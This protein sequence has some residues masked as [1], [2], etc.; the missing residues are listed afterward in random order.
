MYIKYRNRQNKTYKSDKRDI[1]GIFPVYSYIQAVCHLRIVPDD[2][3]RACQLREQSKAVNTWDFYTLVG[4]GIPWYSVL[5][6]FTLGECSSFLQCSPR[7]YLSLFPSMSISSD[8]Q[9]AGSDT[10][11]VFCFL[12]LLSAF[13]KLP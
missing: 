7:P 4:F 11:L 3:K 8:N 13:Q 2:H 5:L 6:C 12:S 1:S 9:V 10:L